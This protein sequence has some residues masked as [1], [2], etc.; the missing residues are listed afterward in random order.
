MVL[1]IDLS[2]EFPHLPRAPI[3]E[4]VIQWQATGT[5]DVLESHLRSHLEGAFPDYEIAPQHSLEAAF[6]GSDKG[7]ELRQRSSWQGFRLTRLSDGNPQFVC[8]FRQDG[9]VVSR[10]A[11]YEGWNQ[12]LPEAI[13]FW[14]TFTEIREPKSIARLSTRYI[15]QMPVRSMVEIAD[16]LNVVTDPL[17]V[18]GVS[19]DTFFHQDTVKLGNLPYIINVRTAL[20]PTPKSEISDKSLIVDVDV[21]TAEG[22]TDESEMELTLKELQHLKNKVFFGL[23]KNP[24]EKFGGIQA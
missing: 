2:K 24:E 13:R 21:S 22:P 16:L 12:F 6:E 19:S 7:M 11:P 23:M 10:L 8:Q 1:E 4:A 15:S 20:Q 3:V 9:I 14:K 17:K 5:K 18:F